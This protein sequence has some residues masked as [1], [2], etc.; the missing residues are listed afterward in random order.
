MN[1][2]IKLS[3]IGGDARQYVTA[4][5]LRSAG[6][7]CITFA[8]PP[9]CPENDTDAVPAAASLGECLAGT[10]AVILGIPYSTD[11]RHIN[12]KSAD[13]AVSFRSLCEKLAPR[14]LILGGK[15]TPEAQATAALYGVDLIDYLE[16]EEVNIHNAVPTAEG[17]LAIAM[18]ELPVTIC[19]SR[20]AVLGYGRI[21]RVL[22]ERLRAL[23]ARVTVAVRKK[24]D[25]AWCRLS[26]FEVVG[27]NTLDNLKGSQTVFNTVPACVLGRRELEAI[28]RETLYIDLASKPGG[29]DMEAARL[30]GCRVI[31]ALS[32]PGKVAVRTAG[33]IIADSVISILRE[34]GIV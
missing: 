3:V 30:L 4:K 25:E 15:V 19:G 11:G 27:F 32:L 1:E 7:D 12:C 31:W 17:A 33:E 34:E 8:M 26:G 16:R 23:G 24:R 13:C 28:G 2:H 29:V 9:G 6:F 22:A 20:V 14:S 21:G 10:S 18:N 5:R